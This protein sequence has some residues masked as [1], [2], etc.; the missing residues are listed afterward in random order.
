M[1][2]GFLNTFL[3]KELEQE[4]YR[5]TTD[6]IQRQERQIDIVFDAVTSEYICAKSKDKYKKF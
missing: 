3:S 1:I 4:K 2:K 5:E 6:N